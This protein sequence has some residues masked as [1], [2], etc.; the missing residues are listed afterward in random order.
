MNEKFY[1][2]MT[3]EVNEILASMDDECRQNPELLRQRAIYWIEQNAAGF[4]EQWNQV[5]C[6]EQVAQ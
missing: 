4:R 3:A 6:L 1:E 5:H 2:F